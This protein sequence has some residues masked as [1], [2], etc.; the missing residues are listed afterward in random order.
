MSLAHTPKHSNSS[1]HS[2]HESSPVVAW[3]VLEPNPLSV[4]PLRR[5]ASPGQLWRVRSIVD[6]NKPRSSDENRLRST[7]SLALVSSLNDTSPA[8]P[9]AGRAPVPR[10]GKSLPRVT[11]PAL[12]RAAHCQLGNIPITVPGSGPTLARPSARNACIYHCR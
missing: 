9:L 1:P 3:I 2:K 12:L 11:L 4:T 8:R 6:E 7:S 10:T 5:P